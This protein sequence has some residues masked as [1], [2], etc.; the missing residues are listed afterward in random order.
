MHTYIQ[1]RLSTVNV[2]VMQASEVAYMYKHVAAYV[3][4][5]I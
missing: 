1:N 5:N 4:D 2:S 3:H